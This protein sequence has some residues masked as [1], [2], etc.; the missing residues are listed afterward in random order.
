MKKYLLIT[1][2][3]IIILSSMFM[4]LYTGASQ[5]IPV[6]SDEFLRLPLHSMAIL[7]HPELS[8]SSPV[9]I[10]TRTIVTYNLTPHLTNSKS[11]NSLI[12]TIYLS[13]PIPNI[14]HQLG[15]SNYA[16]KPMLTIFRRPQN[17]F[18]VWAAKKQTNG[19]IT[20]IS[21]PTI[22]IQTFAFC[23]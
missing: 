10:H 14:P 17:I 21:L 8:A 18:I 20:V 23:T 4:V 3:L 9:L 11:L 1:V 16:I 19:A 13:K 22:K 5:N 6:Y 12:S 2:I 7:L 15:P